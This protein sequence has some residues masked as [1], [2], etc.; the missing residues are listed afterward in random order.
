[1]RAIGVS[2]TACKDELRQHVR[3]FTAGV[4]KSFIMTSYVKELP[5]ERV[6]P[7]A[8]YVKRLPSMLPTAPL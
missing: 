3:S 6:L 1:M 7:T 5:I 2:R 8:L 4:Y